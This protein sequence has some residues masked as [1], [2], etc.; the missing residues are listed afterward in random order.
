MGELSGE[1]MDGWDVEVGEDV[2]NGEMVDGIEALLSEAD[3]WWSGISGSGINSKVM[4]CGSLSSMGLPWLL[5]GAGSWEMSIRK[6]C[7]GVM[8][9]SLSV[10]GV[11][12]EGLRTGGRVRA[13]F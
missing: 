2:G 12:V 9:V 7:V 4:L 1:R 11:R 3:G 8:G 10:S 6:E 5:V 13:D